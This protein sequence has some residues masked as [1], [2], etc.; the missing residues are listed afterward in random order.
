MQ[1][2]SVLTYDSAYDQGC[3]RNQ[4]HIS[5]Q[6]HSLLLLLRLCAVHQHLLTIAKLCLQP[7]KIQD[8]FIISSEKLKRG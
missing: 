1:R 8:Y 5:L 2:A 6:A 4:S 3:S 7:V